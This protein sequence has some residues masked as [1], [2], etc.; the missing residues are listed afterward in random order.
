MKALIVGSFTGR[1]GMGRDVLA[2][3][4]NGLFGPVWFASNHS[5]NMRSVSG[6]S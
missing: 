1:W 4:F 6:S 3:D 5:E 2:V